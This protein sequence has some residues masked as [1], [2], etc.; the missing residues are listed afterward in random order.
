MKFQ[1]TKFLL[2]S[3]SLAAIACLFHQIHVF[4]WL[5]LFVGLLL[6][7]KIINGLLYAIPALVVPVGYM[8]AAFVYYSIPVEFNSFLQFVL[9]DFYSGHANIETGL[10]G[11]LFTSM[12][13][14]RT[15][16]QVHGYIFVLLK[17]QPFYILGLAIPFVF[18]LAAT[19]SLRSISFTLK[20]DAKAFFTP[21]IIAF[22]LHF[23][24]AFISIGNAEFM[25][26][27]PFLMALTIP[28]LVP[29]ETRVVSYIASG[30]LVWNILLGV[31][32]LHT[33]VLDSSYMVANKVLYA[34]DDT[35]LFI[36]NNKPHIQ[37]IVLY[38]SGKNP[39]NLVSG[40]N[41]TDE[42]NLK[43]SIES[44]LEHGVVVYTDCLYRPKTLSRASLL[45]GNRDDVFE[46]FSLLKIDSVET[47]SGRYYF[48]QVEMN[49]ENSTF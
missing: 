33:Y 48:V 47:I 6:Q 27:L 49:K 12:S 17:N 30:M 1:K 23:I 3:G 15:F 40:I 4:W 5:A 11:V 22:L 26:M 18:F 25:V 7:R 13:F 38:N 41:S 20:I 32:P 37:N 10:T 24:F 43:E 29:S 14:F 19:F 16:L 21:H 42:T 2:L 34:G 35:T 9:R 28:F 45:T 44:L 39:L 31:L 8:L 36:C 46:G